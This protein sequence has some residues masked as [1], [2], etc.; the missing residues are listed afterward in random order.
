MQELEE[1]TR[2][3]LTVDI[4]ILSNK[5]KSSHRTARIKGFPVTETCEDFRKEVKNILPGGKFSDNFSFGFIG[6]K[7]KKIWAFSDSDLADAHSVVM[8]EVDNK[9]KQENKR[10]HKF[11]K[12]R[13]CFQIFF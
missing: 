8:D 12:K 11:S 6:K 9:E 5:K 2:Q 7:Q 3:R 1:D 10:K 13:T 4:R